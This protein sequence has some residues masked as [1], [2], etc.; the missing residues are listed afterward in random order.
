MPS[1]DTFTIKPIAE[2]IA[3]YAGSGKGWVDPFAGNNSPAEYTNDHNPDTKAQS[4]LEAMDFVELFKSKKFGNTKF[5]GAF[6]DPPYSYRQVSE[7]YKVIGKKATQLDTSTRF[8]NRVLNPL[9]DIIDKEGI[10]ISFG[11]NTN[12][13]G[14]N[15]GFKLKKPLMGKVMF[16]NSKK[17]KRAFTV[18]MTTLESYPLINRIYTFNFK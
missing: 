6:F 5:V 8:F 3:R 15:R 11:W 12:A 9:A 1:K 13:M 17:H 10:V 2:L 4:H 14:K 16:C 18:K 7:H